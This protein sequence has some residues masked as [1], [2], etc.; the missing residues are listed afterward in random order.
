[1]R[2]ISY[3]MYLDKVYGCF[4]GKAISGNIGAPHEGVKMP[5]NFEFMPEM[6]NCELPNDDLDLQVAWLDVL[7]KYGENF[8]SYHLLERFV[9]CCDYS[10]GEYSIMRKNFMRGIYPPYSG[11]FCNDFYIEG[12]GCPIRSEI[13]GCVAV[14]NMKLAQ[15]LSVLDGQMDHYGESIWAER[16]MAAL[17][18]EAFFDNNIKSLILKALA[19]LPENSKFRALVEYTMELC[20][21]YGDIKVVLTKLLFKYGHP[22]CTNMYQNMGIIIASLLM[23]DGDII[24]TSLMALN[25]GFDTDCTCATAGAVIGLL[26]GADDLIKSYGLTEVT[27]TLGVDIKR[28]SDKIYD[29]AEDIAK[30]GVHFARVRNKDVHIE[31]APCDEYDFAKKP[32]VTFEAEY[33]DMKPYVELGGS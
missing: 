11:K 10:P 1:M 28:R 13:W 2:K 18:S 15:E 33:E 20:E 32:I 8:T 27:Y 30:M 19:I 25:C 3:K 29:L 5:M 26:R 14:D 16:F 7:E 21:K 23:G 24:K 31:N 4:V 22:D 6:I 17:E 12:M 9:S